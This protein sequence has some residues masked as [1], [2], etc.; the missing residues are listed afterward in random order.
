MSETVP[1]PVDETADSWKLTGRHVLTILILFFGIIIMISIVFTTLAVKSFRGEDIKQSYRQGIEYNSALEARAAQSQLGWSVAV[2]VV[3]DVSKRTLVVKL[4]DQSE[5]GLNGATF[6]GRLRH[7]VDTAL[8]QPIIFE[9]SGD[10]IAR[11]DI[12]GLHGQWTLEA[13]TIR[14][15]HQ[16]HFRR[17]LD[18][19]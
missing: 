4:L 6:T 10:G 13:D 15:D 2:N 18:L 19:R 9:T 3:G 17:D 14:G 1:I 7:P 12:S 16:F 8:D 11:A 5:A